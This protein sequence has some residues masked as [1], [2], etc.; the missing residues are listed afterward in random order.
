MYECKLCKHGVSGKQDTNLLKTS[1][2]KSR[3]KDIFE[4]EIK[5][6]GKD[7][8][9]QMKIER[10]KLLQICVEIVTV[11]HQPFADL[12]KTGTQ[13][14]IETRLKLFNKKYPLN[15]KCKNLIPVKD[16]LKFTAAKIRQKITDEMK[17]RL[18]SM[19]ADIVSKNNRS[20]L[21]IY[22]H[23]INNGN[24]VTRC[25]G[26]VELHQ[27][28][29]GKYLSSV[30]KDCLKVY[31]CQ[32]NQIISLTTDNGSN[33][34]T[35]LN[36]MNEI[37]VVDYDTDDVIDDGNNNNETIQ[38]DEEI[39]SE[40][41]VEEVDHSNQP[42]YDAEISNILNEISK[43][44]EGEINDLG[45]M[46]VPTNDWIIN[47]ISEEAD[48]ATSLTVNYYANFVFINGICCSAHTLQLAVK[49]ALAI[50]NTKHSNVITLTK[51]VAKFF[52]RQ[53]T[54][55]QMQNDGIKK[56]LPCLNTETRWS[57][58]YMMV[59]KILLYDYYFYF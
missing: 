53:N 54:I 29:D 47:N 5:I 12:Y 31:N 18:V 32:M 9:I 1:H 45:A 3:H 15:L 25:I 51:E 39:E 7:V 22:T 24:L 44:D 21:G 4:E 49:D 55:Y 16:H 57:S 26:M 17:N 30:V 20:I 36:N 8:D 40:T 10:L 2:L 48:L 14:L 56:K 23:Y 37:V 27:K 19:T 33:M 11:N 43:E 59:R 46:L 38:V 58:T 42:L 35:M 28:H 41:D 50:L 52:R 34:G 6:D 13:K